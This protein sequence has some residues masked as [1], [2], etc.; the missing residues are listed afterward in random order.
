MQYADFFACFLAQTRLS[1]AFL[2]FYFSFAFHFTTC[3]FNQFVVIFCHIPQLSPF[4]VLFIF[5]LDI[6]I[7][8]P[9]KK[10]FYTRYPTVSPVK[11]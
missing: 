1:T 8:D 5:H 11:I 10:L 6:Y 2:T 4:I 9:S 3:H 7:T